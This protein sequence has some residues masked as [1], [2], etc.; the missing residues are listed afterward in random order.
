MDE[1]CL[2]GLGC[3]MYEDMPQCLDINE[4]DL[5]PDIC[6]EE[7]GTVCLNLISTY[8][9][10]TRTWVQL[11]IVN[12]LCRCIDPEEDRVALVI[13]GKNGAGFKNIEVYLTANIKGVG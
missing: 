1:D 3:G 8:R 5:D 7:P 13:G 10:G 2:D 4:C 6:S 9:F 11:T 12:Y